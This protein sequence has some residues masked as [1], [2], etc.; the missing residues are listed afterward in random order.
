MDKIDAVRDGEKWTEADYVAALERR[1]RTG[2]FA[3]EAEA[4]AKEDDTN[5][6]AP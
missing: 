6:E 1:A 2:T 5:A 4:P 3:D